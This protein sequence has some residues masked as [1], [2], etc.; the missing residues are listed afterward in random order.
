MG[1]SEIWRSM[2]RVAS[3]VASLPAAFVRRMFRG[4]SEGDIWFVAIALAIEIFTLTILIWHLGHHCVN[5]S[6]LVNFTSLMLLVLSVW[7]SLIRAKGNWLWP[8][9]LFVGGIGAWGLGVAIGPKGLGEFIAIYD[10][11]VHADCQSTRLQ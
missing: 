3:W 8:A 11:V 6:A 4:L 9:T 10:L 1:A 7:I 2:K 5:A